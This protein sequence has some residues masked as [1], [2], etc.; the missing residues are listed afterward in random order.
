MGNTVRAYVRSVRE[1]VDDDRY[2]GNGQLKLVK[3]NGALVGG[4]GLVIVVIV[5]P[6]KKLPSAP[7]MKQQLSRKSD[8]YLG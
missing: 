3:S 5:I 2:L 4:V 8:A 1:K 7:S 6:F